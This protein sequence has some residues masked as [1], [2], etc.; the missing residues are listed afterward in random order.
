MGIL[1]DISKDVNAGGP[2]RN[3]GDDILQ[4]PGSSYARASVNRLHYGDKFSALSESIARKN[5]DLIYL[6]PPFRANAIDRPA[7]Q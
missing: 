5:V 1:Y 7:G 3:S 2:C 6:D 4:T